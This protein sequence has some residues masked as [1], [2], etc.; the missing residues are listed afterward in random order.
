MC[1][2]NKVVVIG[3]GLMGKQI[4]LNCAISGY[5]TVLNDKFE[6]ALQNADSWKNDYLH[7]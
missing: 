1:N 5:E 4:A 2:I 7:S 6:E 3:A